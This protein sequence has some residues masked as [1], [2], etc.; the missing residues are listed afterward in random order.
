MTMNSEVLKKS[1]E[2][3]F[4][5]LSQMRGVGKLVLHLGEIIC[6][7][8]KC[9]GF[10]I[11]DDV[12]KFF[13][14][15]LSL[16]EDGNTC[17]STEVTEFQKK[18]ATKWNSLVELKRSE[19]PG[20]ELASADDFAFIIQKGLAYI[21]SEES[22][23]IVE[24]RN[25]NK[26]SLDIEEIS[27]TKLFILNCHDENSKPYLYSTKYFDAKCII[28]SVGQQVFEHSEV[29]SQSDI[30]RYIEKS[31][32]LMNFKVNAKQAEAI[33]RGEK[34]N[35]IITGGPGTGKTTVVV[36]LLWNLL[37]SN[38][39]E[40]KTWQI[41]LAAPSGKAADRMH[42]SLT[43]GLNDIR[44]DIL[45]D[46]EN[47]K[48]FDHLKNLE[49]STIHRLLRY[50]IKE[51]GFSINGKNKF[52][53][54][55]IFVIDEASM[56]DINLFA[57]F[58]QALPEKNAKVFILGDPFQLPSVDA[59]AV[60]GEILNSR[61]ARE[62]FIV[63]LVE[64]RRFKSDSNIGILATAI[65]NCA[66]RSSCEVPQGTFTS[67]TSIGEPQN[68]SVRF[69]SVDRDCIKEE[70]NSIETLSK[71]WNQ[72]FFDFPIRA[73]QIH[74]RVENPDETEKRNRNDLWEDS[75][76]RRTL[77]AER[78]GIR[79]VFQLNK[80]ACEGIKNHVKELNKEIAQ[81]NKERPEEISE[82]PK[83]SMY[84]GKY[85]PGELLILTQNQSMYKLYNGDTG[86]VI[87]D[88]ES[89]MPYLM[90][91][92]DNFVFY[93]LSLLPEDSLE[94]AF[95]ITIHKS[96]GSEYNHVLMFLPKQKGH[97][98]L[99]NQIVYTGITRAKESVTIIAN[100]ETFQAASITVTERET[101][102]EL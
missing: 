18:W 74:P 97:P 58:L 37:K 4:E 49:S 30:E 78:G 40:F 11:D 8:A 100:Q 59:G 1:P 71:E 50:S 68:N 39:D 22:K 84:S 56:I 34:S 57:A 2:E 62:N 89:Q 60:L 31:G 23:S 87:F 63:E 46:D 7:K 91:K 24:I 41:H 6:D 32:E 73:A 3:F 69:I 67:G 26:K 51:S 17:F 12:L 98:L 92:K 42:E 102:I 47:K 79:G 94:P 65:K 13:Y 75:L 43:K 5:A 96:Q 95:A 28:E 9:D 72:F 52:S 93:P 27:S 64:S 35:L 21:L 54:K 38:F 76:K 80:L 85:F 86:I 19:F 88:R 16:Q 15:L 53:E 55:S 20:E 33:L 83:I 90:L 48:I 99:T 36:F 45:K 66:T 77:S 10:K 44:T 81:R 82:E 61:R 29:P 14:M 25:V 70:E 101:G